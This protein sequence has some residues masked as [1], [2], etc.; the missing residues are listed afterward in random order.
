MTVLSVTLIPGFEQNSGTL[1]YTI[2]V[3]MIKLSVFETK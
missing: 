2:I 3:I 1:K